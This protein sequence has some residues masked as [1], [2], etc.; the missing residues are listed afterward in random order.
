MV[1]KANVNLF[2]KE[3][4]LTHVPVL[5]SCLVF[6]DES[7]EDVLKFA[8][9]KSVVGSFPEREGLV[10]KRLTADDSFKAISNKWLCKFE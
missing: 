4:F 8:E 6:N 1:S 9:A 7:V 3:T 10:F 2:C 5:D